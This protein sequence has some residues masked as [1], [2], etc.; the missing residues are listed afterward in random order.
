MMNNIKK[1][2]LEV[3]TLLLL[4][5]VLTTPTLPTT[6]LII[7]DAIVS[8]NPDNE[9]QINSDKPDRP[10]EEPDFGQL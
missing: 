8:E 3:G 1:L 5:L 6:S 2:I 4:A 7:T 10:K 9:A